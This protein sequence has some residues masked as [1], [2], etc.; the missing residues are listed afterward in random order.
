MFEN[1]QKDDEKRFEYLKDLCKES[2]D[3]YLLLLFLLIVFG[4]IIGKC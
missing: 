4:L 3:N 2:L 1:N